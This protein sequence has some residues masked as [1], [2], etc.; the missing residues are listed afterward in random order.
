MNFSI[1]K[2]KHIDAVKD[3]WLKTFS[4]NLL[5]I[6]GQR[7]IKSY[8]INFLQNQKNKGFLLF[9][10]NKIIAFVLY[11]SEK[12]LIKKI[13]LSNFIIIIFSFIKLFLFLEIKKI[14]T[15]FDVLIFLLLSNNKLKIKKKKILNY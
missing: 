6:I 10:R 1:F 11:G 3:L 2:Y 7:I 5:S 14:K 9:H 12:N 8:L 13:F 4:E 15:F